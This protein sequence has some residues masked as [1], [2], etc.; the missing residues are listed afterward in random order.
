[1]RGFIAAR[2]RRTA[3]FAAALACRRR[4]I[5]G[6]RRNDRR[7][8]GSGETRA[9]AAANR[10]PRRRQS[11]DR[12]RFGAGRRGHGDHRKELRRHQPDRPR[13]QWLRKST[14]SW[15]GFRGRRRTSSS[16]AA[17]RRE[18]Y[19][20]EPNCERRI[21]LGDTPDYFEREPQPELGPQQPRDVGAGAP[22]TVRAEPA[23]GAPPNETLPARLEI[24]IRVNPSDNAL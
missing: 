11:A 19:I 14:R 17:R 6:R 1:M 3:Q 15:S 22:R 24:E 21:T 12:R 2:V 4:L 7:H 8:D 16:I 9:R 13:F 23:H 20:C 10:H 5:R 18:S